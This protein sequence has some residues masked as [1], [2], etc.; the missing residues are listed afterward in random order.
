[1]KKFA[2]RFVL[3]YLCIGSIYALVIGMNSMEVRFADEEEHLFRIDHVKTAHYNDQSLIICAEIRNAFSD[4]LGTPAI[5]GIVVPIHSLWKNADHLD[6]FYRPDWLKYSVYMPHRQLVQHCDL[7]DDSY[8]K[9]TIQRF[10]QTK[11]G[12]YIDGFSQY[13][14][15][16]HIAQQD[17]RIQLF[18]I[19]NSFTGER[20]SK[21]KQVVFVNDKEDWRGNSFM[22]IRLKSIFTEPRNLWHD[23]A[24]AFIL[25]AVT[26]P[27]QIIMWKEYAGAH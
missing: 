18:E 19:P 7:P 6:D 14:L 20:F 27:L 4:E 2:K 15:E 26:F 1:M 24:S 12:D 9:I 16:R 25:D 5:L 3:I 22:E 17:G 10:P 13:E 23:Y 8:I 11:P 21:H